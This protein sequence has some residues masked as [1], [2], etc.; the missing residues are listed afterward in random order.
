MEGDIIEHQ[1]WWLNGASSLSRQ[2]EITTFTSIEIKMLGT[3]AAADSS[4]VVLELDIICRCSNN[5]IESNIICK[6]VNIA[7]RKNFARNIIDV[8]NEEKW[9][10]H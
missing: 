9:T 4:D 6:E 3:E 10:Q 1:N 8:N 2:Q 7:I 5:S